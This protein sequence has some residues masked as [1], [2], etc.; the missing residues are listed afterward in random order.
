MPA[1]SPR[2]KSTNLATKLT[3]IRR[4]LAL[5]VQYPAITAELPAMP[6]LAGLRLQGILPAATAQQILIQP[7]VHRVSCWSIG[8]VQRGKIP[9]QLA[10]HDLFE[11]VKSTR[12][13]IFWEN[14]RIPLSVS[15]T[16]S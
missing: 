8:A 6:E 10:M 12:S 2:W 4:A 9:L 3:P 7:G 11:E 13:P 14:C 1:A 15:S 16:F 5:M